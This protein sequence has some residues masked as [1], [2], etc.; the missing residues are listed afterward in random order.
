MVGSV[1][2]VEALWDAVPVG[3][4]IVDPRGRIVRANQQL[5]VLLGVT[6]PELENREL[7][8]FVGADVART[9][10]TAAELPAAGVLAH[11]LTKTGERVDMLLHRRPGLRPP[12][13]VS[14]TVEGGARSELQSAETALVARADELRRTT[15]A[16]TSERA[17]RLLLET[18]LDAANMAVWS[19]ELTTGVMTFYGPIERVSHLAPEKIP[20]TFEDLLGL[21]YEDDRHTIVEE[22]QRARRELNGFHTRFRVVGSDGVMRWFDGHGGYIVDAAGSPVRSAGIL[23]NVT[24]T[25]QAED[26]RRRLHSRITNILDSVQDGFV[27]LDRNWHYIYVNRRAAEMF[28]REPQDLI[29]KHIWTEF[30]EG[31]GQ[32]FHRA[33]EKALADQVPA[34][35]E[36]YYEPWDRWFENRIYPSEDGLTIF[37]TEITARKHAEDELRGWRDRLRALSTRL[38]LVREQEAARLAHEVHD[39]MGQTLTALKMDIVWLLRRMAN[40]PQD[41]EARARFDTTAATKLDEMR[42]LIDSTIAAVRR[43]SADLRPAILDELGLVA[44]VRWYGDEFRKRTRIQYA[45]HEGVA[46]VDI[47]RETATVFFRI[48]QEALTGIARNSGAHR[49]D[50]TI[51]VRDNTLALTVEDDGQAFDPKAVNDPRALALLGMQ[52]RAAAVDGRVVF[53][54]RPDGGT[55]I[56]VSAHL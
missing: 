27:A 29:G 19:R 51:D 41:P 53:E 5:L 34:F 44:A 55:R 6:P 4:A 15:D 3:V 25:V 47:P 13:V 1:S 48:F 37:F 43:I 38:Q 36:A 45:L 22:I 26:E 10:L 17:R 7:A 52:E 8:S 28:G 12:I 18:A 50:A 2:E 56:A 20:K 33:Y 40:P 31:V 9:V 14:F 39:D 23:L 30:P 32:P 54:P 42:G 46:Q 35:L 24:K 16:L 11:V 49:V 21:V